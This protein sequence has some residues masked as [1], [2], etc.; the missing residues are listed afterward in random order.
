MT[1]QPDTAPTADPETFSESDE[2]STPPDLFAALSALYG[3]FDVDAAAAAW[4]RK[5]TLWCGSIGGLSLDVVAAPLGDAF[6]FDWSSHGRRNFS[7]VWC[8]PPYSRGSLERWVSFFRER[9][10]VGDL[11]LVTM[12]VPHYT[13]EGWWRHV[14]APA[15]E[16]LLTTSGHTEIGPRTQVCWEHLTVEVLRKRG[17]VHF[18]ERR[19]KTGA[20]RHSSAAVTFA[21]P[22]VLEPLRAGPRRLGPKRVM[23]PELTAAMERLIGAGHSISTACEL[24]GIARK[25][26][27]RTL[28][29]RATE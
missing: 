8:N 20:A 4:N 16:L 10:L 25:T 3:P 17:R 7:R 29:R 27:Y 22:G 5:C 15:G 14:E 19:G 6:A 24:V 23:T 1:Q 11:P 2:W 26:W 18:V 12:L 21:R 28:E 13:A 9:V